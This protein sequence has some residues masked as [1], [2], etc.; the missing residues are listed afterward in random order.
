MSKHGMVIEF[1]DSSRNP[2][3]SAMASNRS[4]KDCLME[5]LF[6]SVLM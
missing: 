3:S 5:L 4:R 1:A 2:D 6:P